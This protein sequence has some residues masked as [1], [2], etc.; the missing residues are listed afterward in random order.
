MWEYKLPMLR[1]SLHG[2]WLLIENSIVV[3]AL[4]VMCVLAHTSTHVPQHACGVLRTV[5]QSGS[6]LPSWVPVV[7]PQDSACRV[8]T[9]S[10]SSTEPAQKLYPSIAKSNSLVSLVP[11]Q[12]L[13]PR[14]GVF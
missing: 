1:W 9:V 14:V 2:T 8:S 12:P 3:F 11:S 5:M 6:L 13:L 7:E 10:I 4:W